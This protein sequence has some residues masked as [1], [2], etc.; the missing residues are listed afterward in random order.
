MRYV[1]MLRDPPVALL[2]RRGANFTLEKDIP[3]GLSY[4]KDL[5]IKFILDGNS[6]EKKQDLIVKVDHV[7]STS[8]QVYKAPYTD[9]GYRSTNNPATPK[10]RLVWTNTAAYVSLLYFTAP[11]EISH[12]S[13]VPLATTKDIAFLG[14]ALN[15]DL[16][17]VGVQANKNEVP[18]FTSPDGT[19]ICPGDQFTQL[20]PMSLPLTPPESHWLHNVIFRA[21]PGEIKS[22]VLYTIGGTTYAMPLQ[23]HAEFR[24]VCHHGE[25]FCLEPHHGDAA[26][27]ASPPSILWQCIEHIGYPSLWK[28][29][30][31][32]WKALGIT[33]KVVRNDQSDDATRKVYPR[34]KRSVHG[35]ILY[36]QPWIKSSIERYQR[37]SATFKRSPEV[38]SSWDHTLEDGFKNAQ[39]LDFIVSLASRDPGQR[40]NEQSSY[41]RPHQL[42][43]F[44]FGSLI[45]ERIVLT[46]AHCVDQIALRLQ[47]DDQRDS[48][49]Q[50]TKTTNDKPQG[51]DFVVFKDN[52]Q[53]YVIPIDQV[54]IHPRYHNQI[55]EAKNEDPDIALVVMR[56]DSSAREALK[57]V[58][59]PRLARAEVD[60]EEVDA[61]INAANDIS[62]NEG[63]ANTSANMVTSGEALWGLHNRKVRFLSSLQYEDNGPITKDNNYD[64]TFSTMGYE[65]ARLD[66]LTDLRTYIRKGWQ[67]FFALQNRRDWLL[68]ESQRIS[69]ANIPQKDLT[70]ELIWEHMLQE[71]PHNDEDTLHEAVVHSLGGCHSPSMLCFSAY[72]PLTRFHRISSM[73][74][75]D[76]GSPIFKRD[77][78]PQALSLIAIKISSTRSELSSS[79]TC[80][81]LV[82]KG[83]R[84]SPYY[85]WIEEQIEAHSS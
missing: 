11:S 74:S 70:P 53:H 10:T 76:S 83:L 80:A 63:E 13:P 17:T 56:P 5:S 12:I 20:G 66:V 54:I 49:L 73:C 2:A 19:I 18:P 62:H 68:A 44:C 25:G 75:G 82:G 7:D 40:P 60:A 24:A 61:E 26:T 14:D 34:L 72:Q 39:H 78:P 35:D 84:I 15:H 43:D 42:N 37:A 1:E 27:S 32:T 50:S 41:V 28:S 69:Q 3:Q 85:S 38:I 31:G 29:P 58:T 21:F 48:D 30:A 79:N 23:R 52:T 46:A 4:Q 9:S 64:H 55:N 71:S 57:K 65:L 67:Q 77:A 81:S 47:A 8:E 45:T 51:D 33:M 59:F 36:Y 6:S 22:L 16:W